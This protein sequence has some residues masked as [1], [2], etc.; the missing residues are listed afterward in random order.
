MSLRSATQSSLS[1]GRAKKSVVF[2]LEA[3][4]VTLFDCPPPRTI[5]SLDPPSPAEP[6]QDEAAE[7]PMA[8]DDEV[9]IRGGIELSWDS[10]ERET[11][12]NSSNEA[13]CSSSLSISHTSISVV[14]PEVSG[15]L[16]DVEPA[17]VS[18]ATVA[19]PRRLS[20]IPCPAR[21][22]LPATL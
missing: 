9:T 22:I 6:T 1:S 19:A 4:S 3:N 20:R 21:R 8:E 18:L 11:V 14:G 2:N 5:T 17:P 10:V 12:P 15:S 13:M 7:E 16:A